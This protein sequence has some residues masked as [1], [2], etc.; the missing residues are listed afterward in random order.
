MLL[1]N[2]G[3]KQRQELREVLDAL[4]EE[5]DHDFKRG[6]YTCGHTERLKGIFQANARGFG[7]V[8]PEDGTDDIFIPEECLGNAFQGDEVEYIMNVSSG[9][10]AAGGKD[11]RNYFA[12]SN[13]Y[14]R[15]V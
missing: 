5:G 15:I 6:K 4:V 10:K 7:F 3:R 13:A 2:S 1:I 12:R 8:T 9:R 14:C 11:R